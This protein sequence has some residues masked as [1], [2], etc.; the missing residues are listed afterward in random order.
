MPDYSSRDVR[1]VTIG[2]MV[3]WADKEGRDTVSASIV[4][5]L[6]SKD[7]RTVSGPRVT[8]DV[9]VECD[10][11]ASLGETEA[12]LLEAAH[13]VLTRVCRDS[14]EDVQEVHRRWRD[15]RNMPDPL[16]ALRDE[17]GTDD[18]GNAEPQKGG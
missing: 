7:E 18:A 1:E 2:G 5:A 13:G 4:F 11:N 9:A 10:R 6:S 16:A 17:L 12:R 15:D 8:V 3:S 14:L